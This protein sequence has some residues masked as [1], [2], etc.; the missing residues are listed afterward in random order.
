MKIAICISGLPRSFKR[1][2]PLLDRVFLSKYDCDIFI[3]TWDWQVNQ[4]QK[5]QE[6]QD[7]FGKPIP[8]VGTHWWPQDGNADEFIKLFRPKKSEVETFND[9]TLETKF[10]YSLY[11]NYGINNSFLPMFY[12]VW[13]ANELR[14]QYEKENNI[15]YDLVLRT[16][17]DIYYD[18]IL[19]EAEIKNALLGHGFCRTSYQNP[20]TPLGEPEHISDIYFLSNP[21]KSTLYANF[22]LYHQQVLEHTKSF[23]AEVNLETYLHHVGVQW[24]AT[25]LHIDSLR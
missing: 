6:T 7:Q 9:D 25:S 12:K 11:K 10:N 15:Q 3:S 20:N 13:R 18:G 2:Y 4:I 17:G 19:S 16:R 5:K 8:I 14:L 22:W 21:E 24:S 1:S 23:I